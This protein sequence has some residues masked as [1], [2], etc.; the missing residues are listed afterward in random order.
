MNNTN[1]IILAIF[2]LYFILAFLAIFNLYYIININQDI[3]Q[4]K[5]IHIKLDT[6][7]Y[8]V[9]DCYD[10]CYYNKSYCME[11]YDKHNGMEYSCGRGENIHFNDTL[12][13]G[14]YA[15]DGDTCICLYDKQIINTDPF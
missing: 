12:N 7:L 3:N 11:F 8:N 13:E 1:L 10:M 9:S 14:Q 15:T 5:I 6:S 2:N 4:V